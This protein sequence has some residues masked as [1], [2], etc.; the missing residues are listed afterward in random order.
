MYPVLFRIGD[1]EV[2]SFGVMVA[3]AALV[4]RIG[5]SLTKS[6]DL[7]EDFISGF[8]PYE[9]FGRPVAD[10]QILANGRFE[11]P[12]AAMRAALDLLLG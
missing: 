10:G 4:S 9:R 11:G 6:G 5:D 12:R 8:G 7:G 1:F 2:T 3:V